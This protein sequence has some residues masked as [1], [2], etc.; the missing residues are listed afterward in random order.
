MMSLD[1]AGACADPPDA[2]ACPRA[3]TGAT[4]EEAKITL[5]VPSDGKYRVELL[6][7]KDERISVKG[8]G[9]V[10]LKTAQGGGQDFD[11]T[12]SDSAEKERTVPFLEWYLLLL[13]LALVPIFCRR[14]RK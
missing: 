9:V 14:W 12:A 11:T 8:Q 7:F 1:A 3:E 6:V 4:T 2:G 13:P 5:E 10:N